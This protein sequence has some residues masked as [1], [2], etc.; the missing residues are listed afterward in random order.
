MR[1]TSI[2]SEESR[3]CRSFVSQQG[4]WRRQFSGE[5]SMYEEVNVAELINVKDDSL[6]TQPISA[7]H[8]VTWIVFEKIYLCFNC[9]SLVLR[10]S[11]LY[12]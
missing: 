7:L 9:Q 4:R 10:A 11:A 6:K 8:T 1:I 12:C 3:H 2:S 5:L